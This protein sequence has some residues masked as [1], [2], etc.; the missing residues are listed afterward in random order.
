MRTLKDLKV[1]IFADGADKKGMVELNANPLV[2]GMTTNPS[3]M[4]KAGVTE[5]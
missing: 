1:K 5:F 3:L 4:R 2:Q